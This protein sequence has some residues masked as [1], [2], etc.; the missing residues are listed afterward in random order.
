MIRPETSA[1]EAAIRLVNEQA[2]ER[3]GEANLVEVLRQNHKV[4]LSLVAVITGQVVGH[5]LFCPVTIE[6]DGKSYSAI[7]LG[8]MAVLP[9]FQRQGI[10]SDLVQHGLEL[11]RQDH[12]VVVVLG[13]TEFYTRFGFVPATT[14]GVRCTF[15]VPEKY[16]ML[17]EL[18][19]GT[20]KSGT[21][22]Y[23]PEFD[24]V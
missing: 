14:Y 9:E 18:S 22:H 21:V 3:D 8:P 10:G 5:I 4:V 19:P 6:A 24:E 23:P 1:D 16:F 13:H 12:D 17:V 2:F 15:G 7:G 11:L 20:A